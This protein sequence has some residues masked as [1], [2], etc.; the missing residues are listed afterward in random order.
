MQKLSFSDL[1]DKVCVITGGA[2]VIGRSLI[3]GLASLGVKAVILDLD[4]KKSRQAAEE[5]ADQYNTE[6]LGIAANVLQRESLEKAREEINSRLGKIDLLI[7]CAGG[8]SPKA[9]T[10]RE[11]IKDEDL[12]E[13]DKTFFGLQI[14]GFQKVFDLNFIGTLLP[15]MVFAAD[16]VNNGKGAILNIS[17]MNA[18]TPLTK[19]PAYSA[20]KAAIN[21]F[22][23]WLAT[24]FAQTNIRV[25]ALAPGFFLTSQNKFLL[26]DEKSGELTERG[27][28]IINNT[29]CGRFGDPDELAGACAYLM[30]DISSFVSGVVLPVDGGFNAYSGV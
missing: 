29:P 7:N 22:T 10:E 18:F 9:T 30:S 8:N 27:R 4:Q 24:H 3:N 1:N 28:K 11:F 15:T 5:I 23:Q 13:L 6:T 21:N 17:S 2:G 19:I 12:K 26:I 20:A 14:E 16:M 25:N